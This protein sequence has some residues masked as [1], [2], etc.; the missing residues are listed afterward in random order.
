[1]PLVYGGNLMNRLYNQFLTCSRLA[2]HKYR[3]ACSSSS[4]GA[5]NLTDHFWT[6]GDNLFKAIQTTNTS[7]LRS[8]FFPHP[9]FQIN[10]LFGKLLDLRHIFRHFNRADQATVLPDRERLF[11]VTILFP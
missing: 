4:P 7:R 10:H 1:M 6:T 8:P 2:D 3:G 9:C 5:L 11:T